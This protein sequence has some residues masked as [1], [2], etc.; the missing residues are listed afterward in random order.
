MLLGS[1]LALAIQASRFA[2]GTLGAVLRVREPLLQVPAVRFHLG[3]FSLRLK[4]RLGLVPNDAEPLLD[5]LLESYDVC[6]LDGGR[7]TC[8]CKGALRWGHKMPC[9]HIS[10]CRHRPPGTKK[11]LRRRYPL[12]RLPPG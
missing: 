5:G 6:L 7:S 11:N 2:A 8:E 4:L 12:R 9:K 3:D 10:N 1:I